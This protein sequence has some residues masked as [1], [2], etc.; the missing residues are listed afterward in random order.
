MYPAITQF[1]T[2]LRELVDEV[3]ELKATLDDQS[4]RTRS[5]DEGEPRLVGVPALCM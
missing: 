1:D 3:A 5:C 2:R 4:E